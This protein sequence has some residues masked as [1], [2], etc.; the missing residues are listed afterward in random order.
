MG[1]IFHPCSI[2][3]LLND[4]KIKL[5]AVVPDMFNFNSKTSFWNYP[6][7]IRKNNFF[8]ANVSD[9]YTYFIAKN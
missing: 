3:F 4:S 7:S 8:Y 6:V 2:F 5:Y 1:L 9:F